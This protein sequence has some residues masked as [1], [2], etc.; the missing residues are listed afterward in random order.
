MFYFFL[1]A[2]ISLK[3]LTVPLSFDGKDV[4]RSALNSKWLQTATIENILTE[5][6]LGQNSESNLFETSVIISI[7]FRPEI[8]QNKKDQLKFIICIY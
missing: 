6:R 4:N 8:V 5:V 7:F 3:F 1:I 2:T